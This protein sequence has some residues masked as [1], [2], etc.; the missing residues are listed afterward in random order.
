MDYAPTLHDSDTPAAPYPAWRRA[1]LIIACPPSCGPRAYAA[2]DRASTGEARWPWVAV[3]RG[4]LPRLSEET[5][6]SQ[7]PHV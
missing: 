6:M 3:A 4:A 1:T 7:H 2:A 5:K